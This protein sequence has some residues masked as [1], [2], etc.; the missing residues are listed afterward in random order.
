MSTRT[1]ERRTSPIQY[2][3]T[4]SDLVCM[5]WFYIKK[6]P[7]SYRFVYQTKV[8]DLV[9]DCYTHL[10]IANSILCKTD[11]DRKQKR[12]HLLEALGLLN[13]FEAFLDIVRKTLDKE[14][15][16]NNRRFIEDKVW[17]NFAKMINQER[18]LL[19]GILT[20]SPC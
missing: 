10:Q 19:L 4:M 11:D 6:G 14:L 15:K 3:D 1:D 5:T 18:I 9:N 12:R 2:L 16:V 8:C 20:K 7:K 13:S 17:T